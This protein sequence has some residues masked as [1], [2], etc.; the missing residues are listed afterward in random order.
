[1]QEQLSA[2]REKVWNVRADI[3]PPDRDKVERLQETLGLSSVVSTLLAL[4]GYD[5]PSS[6]SDFLYLK[7]EMLCDPFAMMDMEKGVLRISQALEKGEKIVIYGDYDV[8]GVTA[9]CIL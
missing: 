4:R 7:T 5:S 1:M 8:D 2:K 9:V 3:N 6:A